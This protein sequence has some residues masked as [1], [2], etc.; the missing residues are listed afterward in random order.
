MYI[1]IDV[2]GTFTDAVLLDNDG[3]RATAKVATRDDLLSSLL[4]VLDKVMDNISGHK[5]KRVVL[6][7]TMITNLILENKYDPV[8][9]ILIPGPG[10]SHNNFMYNADTKIISGAIDYR[11]REIAPLKKNEIAE[12]A[13]DLAEK[14]YKKAAVIGKFSPRN[15]SHEVEVAK[16]L[17]EFYPGW[18]IELGHRVTGQLNYPRRIISTMLTCA[19][20]EKYKYFINS[21][22]NA[23]EKRDIDA[24]VFMLKADGG[25]VP[26]K[27]SADGPVETIFSGPAASTVGVQALT[28]AGETEVVV[29]IGGTTTDLALILNG[30]PLI[31]SQGASI[32]N[33]ITHVRTLSVRSVAVGGDSKIECSGEQIVVCPRRE[34][35]PYCLGGPSPTPTDALRFLGLT[36]LGDKSKAEKAMEMIG[37]ITGRSSEEAAEKVKDLVVDTI[38][39]EIQDMFYKWEQEPAYRVWE[40]LQRSKE[41][42]NIVIGVGGGAAGFIKQIAFR[43]DASPLIPQYA[44]VANAIGAAV[45]MPILQVTLRADTE[46]GYYSIEEEGLQYKIKDQKFSEGEAVDLACEFLDKKANANSFNM[47]QNEIEVIRRETFN[48]VRGFVTTGK[49]YD[50]CVQ[51]PRKLLGRFGEKGGG[52]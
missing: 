30:Q 16:I 20:K 40:V 33:Y 51:T 43:L 4:D 36:E 3:V 35:Q 10:V 15:K 39:R 49:I 24:S 42:P 18:N 29:D 7:T 25:T 34:G 46:Q 41:K 21:V 28:S 37:G 2:G 50:I 6:S 27:N 22:L 8:G 44:P 13:N 5:I 45:S 38:T 31:S 52:K 9:L 48:M 1:G 17:E 19:S 12:V 14:K 26:I 47:G 23:L 32:K 11:G